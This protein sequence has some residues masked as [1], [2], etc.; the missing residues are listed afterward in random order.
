MF[1]PEVKNIFAS[2]KQMLLSKHMFPSLATMETM[3]TRFQY[4]SLNV[5]PAVASKQ[6]WLTAK[7]KQNRRERRKAIGR[8]RRE[9]Y[10]LLCMTIA[11]WNS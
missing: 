11:G 8:T 6:Q 4:C 5:F 9:S 1:L 2:Q 3:L 10:L 7:S